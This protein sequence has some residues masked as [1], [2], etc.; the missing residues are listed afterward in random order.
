MAV[1]NV[2]H[3]VDHTMEEFQGTLESNNNINTIDIQSNNR[4]IPVLVDRI[5]KSFMGNK[6][7]KI[8]TI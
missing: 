6:E 5:N 8:K 7:R 1:L 2:D 4:F 3:I